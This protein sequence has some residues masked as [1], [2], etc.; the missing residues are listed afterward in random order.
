MAQCLVPEESDRKSS[1]QNAL[2]DAKQVPP[3]TSFVTGFLGTV[4]LNGARIKDTREVHI[5]H[6]TLKPS[7]LERETPPPLTFI[8]SGPEQTCRGFKWTHLP[9]C[10][11][12]GD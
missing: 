11:V 10:S 5:T 6:H 8:C 4:A 1:F 9:S 7:S 2:K 12:C 3:N